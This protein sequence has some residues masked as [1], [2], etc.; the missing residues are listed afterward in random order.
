[1]KL[2]EYQAKEVFARYGLPVQTGTVIDRPDA[3]RGLSIQYPVVVKAQ[4]LV[5]GRG[6]AGGVKLAKTP[7][8]AEAHARAILGMDIKGERVGRVLVVPAADIEAEYYLAFVTDRAARRVAG[9]ASAAGGVEIET[10]ARESPEKIARLDVDPCLGVPSFVARGLGRRLGFSGTLLEEFT[11][12]AAILY[13]LYWDEDADLAEINPLARVGGHLLC[14]DAKLVLDDNAAYRHR[15]LPPS[16]EMT[17]LE[18]EAR[19]HGLAYVELEGDIAVIGN[20]AGLVMSTLDL[21]AHFGGRAANFLDVGGGASEEGMQTA[22]ELVQRKPGVRALFINIFGGITRC[23]DIARGIV[24]RPP[25]VPASI[26]LTG[27][28]EVEAREILK[29]AGI[30]AGIDP[31][32]GAR[33]AVALAKGAGGASGSAAKGGPR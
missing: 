9:I 17:P 16:E 28:N 2:H 31:E 23:D 4:V 6:K 11:R 7:A 24:K 3:V 32:E 20:G 8:E 1:M 13:R 30:T 14:V 21:L 33:A 15:D 22:I 26:R 27:T 19:E 25:R 18:R 12:I 29:T 5:G 10:V